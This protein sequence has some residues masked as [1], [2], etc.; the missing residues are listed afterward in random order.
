MARSVSAKV[1]LALSDFV[2]IWRTCGLGVGLRWL[3]GVVMHVRAAMRSGNLQGVDRFLGPGPF[4][5]THP[6][7]SRRFT[8]AGEGVVSGIREMYARDCYLRGRRGL[9]RDGDV[10]VD[11]G[12][13]IGNFTNLALSH[14]GSV[15]VVAVEPSRLL[16]ERFV[17][18]VG[19]N[20]GFRERVVLI[21]G[22]LG[23]VSAEQQA[24]LA[25]EDDYVDAPW[26]T[27]RQFIERADLERIDF[28][29]C[30]IEG[31]EF[32]VLGQ[33]SQLVERATTIAA[34]I[35]AF[36]GPVEALVES[37]SA[38][39]FKLLGR[40]DHPDGSCVILASRGRT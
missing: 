13:N 8:V 26:L 18:S 1:S 16:S 9:I 22:F 24:P 27:E 40:D 10:V 15:R 34:E 3:L 14:G 6:A 4:V 19:S 32:S 11:L 28:L 20:D 7:C 30:D 17:R 2:G 23:E 37:L 33:G 39:G 35:H 38:R 5:I 36:A 21:R 29:K 25:E 31:G 12:A